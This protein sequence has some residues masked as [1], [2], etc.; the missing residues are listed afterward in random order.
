MQKSK[1]SVAK[2]KTNIAILFHNQIEN[3][4]AIGYSPPR[5]YAQ[6]KRLKSEVNS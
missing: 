4:A 2:H 6:M 3:N 1:S 5:T